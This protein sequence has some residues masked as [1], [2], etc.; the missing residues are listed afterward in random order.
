MSFSS[1]PGSLT[2]CKS[3]SFI[4]RKQYT[5][6][7]DYFVIP[8]QAGIHVLKTFLPTGFRDSGLQRSGVPRILA[9]ASSCPAWDALFW[10]RRLRRSACPQFPTARSPFYL[11]KEPATDA[12]P[13]RQ[14]LAKFRAG[15]HLPSRVGRSTACNRRVESIAKISAAPS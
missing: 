13:E 10:R 4:G 5:V 15:R 11:C 2:L 8:A 7:G 12:R 6:N 14:Y 3:Q 9:L 1:G